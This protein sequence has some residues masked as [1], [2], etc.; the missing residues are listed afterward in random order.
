MAFEIQPKRSPRK[1]LR[2]LVK[3]QVD[4]ASNALRGDSEL[5]VAEVVH[6]VRKRIKRI[7]A[8]VRLSRDLF[9]RD[10][11]R[12]LNH[13]FRDAA[14]PLSELRD[15]SVLVKTLDQLAEYW[16]PSERP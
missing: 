5:P 4:K 9:G 15:A 8:L 3:S 16:I 7:R 2:R 14:R 11:A 13:A 12:R 10:V 6:D 1:N